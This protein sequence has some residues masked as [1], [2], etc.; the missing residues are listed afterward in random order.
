MLLGGLIL[1]ALLGLIPAAIARERGY[2]FAAWWL[3]G[4]LLFIV[5]LPCALLAKPR[6]D[7]LDTRKLAG[8]E[9][10][11]CPHCAELIR[12]EAN[13]CR[14]CGRELSPSPWRPG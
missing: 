2:D 6:Q 1:A 10:R 11:R 14:F 8:G 9:A 3:F 7:V 12:K 13:V 4:A 5:A